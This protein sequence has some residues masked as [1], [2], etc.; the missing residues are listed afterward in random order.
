MEPWA[1]LSP[2][3]GQARSWR[4]LWSVVGGHWSPVPLSGCPSQGPPPL[5]SV[6]PSGS[7]PNFS[8][9]INK[10]PSI[11]L[12]LCPSCLLPT[13]YHFFLVLI[14]SPF[15]W[16]RQQ[17]FFDR[18]HRHPPPLVVFACLPEATAIATESAPSSVSTCGTHHSTALILAHY[19][20]SSCRLM[21]LHSN[22]PPYR[23]SGFG[24]PAGIADT[25]ARGSEFSHPGIHVESRRQNCL[26]DPEIHALPANPSL[27]SVPRPRP[28]PPVLPP[29]SSSLSDYE[30]RP[31]LHLLTSLLLC[32]LGYYSTTTTRPPDS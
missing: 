7:P 8:L 6:S 24:G 31:S 18:H 28:R 17:A 27:P 13:S 3:L 10:T 25:T 29:P 21:P 20:S 30:C 16:Y 14:R 1:Y 12:P 15:T 22:C 11:L 9:A 4:E 32:T 23:L 26:P 5:P 2:R 19:P